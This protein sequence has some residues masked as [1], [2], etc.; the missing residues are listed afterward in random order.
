MFLFYV[1]HEAVIIDVTE[2]IAQGFIV[3]DED[4][5]EEEEQADGSLVMV[6]K[7]KKKRRRSQRDEEDEEGLDE[8][9]LDLVMENT[10]VE[11]HRSNQVRTTIIPLLVQAGACE[12]PSN[13]LII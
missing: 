6:K 1:G 4:E 9:D 7:R 13:E 10:G 12:V 8:D 11:V 2:Q 3:D 5:E